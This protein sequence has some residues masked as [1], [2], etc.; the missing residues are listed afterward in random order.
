MSRI[1]CMMYVLSDWQVTSQLLYVMFLVT[2][3]MTS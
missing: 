1:S 2:V 3:L